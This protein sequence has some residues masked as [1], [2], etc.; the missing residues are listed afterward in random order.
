MRAGTDARQAGLTPVED[1]PV[2]LGQAVDQPAPTGTWQVS[3]AARTAPVSQGVDGA[4]ITVQAP[5]TGSVPVS[6]ELDY[7]KFKNLYGA[8][9]PPGCASSSSR[10]WLPDH[11]RCR[12]VQTYEELETTT[13]PGPRRSPRRST[14]RRTAPSHR[15]WRRPPGPPG[16]SVARAAYRT[17][18]TPPR[19]WR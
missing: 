2:S 11:A 10:E 19:L 16:P 3:V 13:T 17:S 6:V 12:G 9:W 4:L 5:A 1:L 18:V 8:D 7:A 14:R 15:L